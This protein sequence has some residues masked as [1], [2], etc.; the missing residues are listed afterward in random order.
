MSNKYIPID[1]HFEIQSGFAFPSNSFVESGIPVVRMSDLK[2]GK[3]QFENTKYVDASWFK[4]ATPFILK[5]G[6]FLLG[7]SGS[8][9]NY[10]VVTEDDEPAL[11][12]QRVGR[13]RKKNK[14]VDYEYVCFWLKSSNYSQYADIQGEG[15][16]QKNISTKQIGQFQYRNVILK[17]QKKIALIL[18]SIEVAIEKTETLIH[19]YQQIKA[20]LMQDLFTRGVTADGKLRPPREHAPELYKESP[21]GWIPKE[22]D[23]KK[24]GAI[25]EKSGGYLQTGPFG[26]QLHASEYTH[27]GVAVVMPQ[28]INNGKIDTLKIAKIPEKRAQV[29]HRHRLKIDD[30]IIARRGELNRA[31]A[32]TEIER[33]WV[34]GTGCFL[35]RLEGSKL[36]AKF[37]SYVYR[38]DMV[39]RQ[40]GGLAV[41]STMPSLNNAVMNAIYFPHLEKSEQNRISYRLRIMEQQIESLTEQK[42]KLQKQKSG[43]MHDLLTGKVQ[44]KVNQ[45]E[46]AHV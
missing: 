44:V 18:N 8:L 5:R 28:D 35:L 15:A 45:E 21:V 11:L 14:N 40:L 22:W 12:N 17:E 38:H 37:F 2:K 30:I 43:L 32:I 26:S 1:T 24:L 33:N 23:A 9:S 46:V 34:C 36:D 4:L 29:L 27:E 42:V 10:A 19:K 3:L 31:A 13:L 25:L 16:A 39:Q 6:D 7:I 41:G 20:G